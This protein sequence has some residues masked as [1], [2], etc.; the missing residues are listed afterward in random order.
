MGNQQEIPFDISESNA[1]QIM[2][3]IEKSPELIGEFTKSS[4][5]TQ[6]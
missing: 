1:E 2:Q 4:L 3:A 6:M 5:R